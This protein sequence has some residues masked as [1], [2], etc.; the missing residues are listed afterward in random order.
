ML[1]NACLIDER[2][3]SRQ[4]E[5]LLIIRLKQRN[6]QIWL[7]SQP[8]FHGAARGHAVGPHQ[9]PQ[10]TDQAMELTSDDIYFFTLEFDARGCTSITIHDFSSITI[11][12][13]SL[14]KLSDHNPRR[15]VKLQRERPYMLRLK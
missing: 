2:V 8:E 1:P 5:H 13:F 11:H 15:Y 10:Q 12:D 4:R 6:G 3:H 9:V 14:L 7:R